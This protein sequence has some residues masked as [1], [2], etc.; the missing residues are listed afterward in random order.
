MDPDVVYKG[1]SRMM[2]DVDES[3]WLNV[4]EVDQLLGL[5]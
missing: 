4:L 3:V 2:E 1:R 5:S